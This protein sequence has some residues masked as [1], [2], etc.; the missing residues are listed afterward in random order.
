[1]CIIIIFW[2]LRVQYPFSKIT[3]RKLM[4][5]EKQEAKHNN[6][7][8]TKEK[9]LEADCAKREYQAPCKAN[10]VRIEL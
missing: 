1:M 2:E 10:Q 4:M 5:R 7:L 9:R 8:H 6:M 3:H